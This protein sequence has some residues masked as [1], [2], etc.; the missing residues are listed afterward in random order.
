MTTLSQ[1]V[2]QIAEQLPP[3]ATWDEVR[4]QV[5]LRASIER[6]LADVKAGRVVPVEELLAEFG[7]L[8]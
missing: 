1:Q 8:E 3:E 7:M 5:E 2:H 6:G 4:Y